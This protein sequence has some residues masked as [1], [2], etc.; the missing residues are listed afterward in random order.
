MALGWRNQYSR[1][2]DFFLNVYGAYQKKAEA[3]MFIEILLSATISAI[4]IFLALRP[5]VL[6]ILELVKTIQEKEKTIKVMEQKIQN[7]NIAQKIYED[8]SVGI[9]L[10]KASIPNTPEP[11]ILSRQIQGLAEQNSVELSSLAIE[12]IPLVGA[13]E[14]KTDKNLTSLPSGSNP[15]TFSVNIKSANFPL[16]SNILSQLEN[17][18]VP[19]KLDTFTITSTQ[20]EDVINLTLAVGGRSPYLSKEGQNK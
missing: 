17:L 4:F 13:E 19:I 14:V 8:N 5:T 1:Y 9:S 18:R 15:I 10:I 7:L 3:K 12:N 6:T 11:E 2:K 16:I 20:S